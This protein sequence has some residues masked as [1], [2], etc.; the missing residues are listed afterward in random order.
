MN[1]IPGQQ[2]SRI[3]SVASVESEYF[4]SIRSTCSHEVIKFLVCTIKLKEQL[5]T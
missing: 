2:S 5:S 3:F 4:S 1:G